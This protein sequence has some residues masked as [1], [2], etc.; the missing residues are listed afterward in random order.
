MTDKQVSTTS[1]FEQATALVSDL[2]LPHSLRSLSFGVD[3]LE[4]DELE[5]D[6]METR[7]IL[8]EQRVADLQTSNNTLRHRVNELE[9]WAGNIGQW[10]NSVKQWAPNVNNILT[11]HNAAIEQLREFCG[12][13]CP[14]S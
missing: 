6:E 12:Q 8:L 14:P 7:V 9:I 2:K 5:S 3:E 13:R 10:A 1:H 11:S 4:S